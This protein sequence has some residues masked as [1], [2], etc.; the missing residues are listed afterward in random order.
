VAAF[1]FRGGLSYWLTGIVIA[2]NKGGNAT[3]RQC[4]LRALVVWLPV[5]LLLSGSVLA[6]AFAPGN[7]TLDSVFWWLAVL[8]LPLYALAA[9]LNL[10]AGWHDRLVGTTLVPR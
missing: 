9:V 7:A 8:L 4:A 10:E 3:R 1:V 5:G 2:A 6:Q